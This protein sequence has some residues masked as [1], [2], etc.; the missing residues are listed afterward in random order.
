MIDYKEIIDNLQT[1]KVIQLMEQLGATSYIQKENYVIFPTICHNENPE[2]ASM[3]LYYYENT[4]AFVCYTKDGGMSIFKFL[5]HY[6]ETR[7]IEYDWKKDIYDVIVNCSTSKDFSA[8]NR[9]R[10]KSKRSIYNRAPVKEL[11]VYP[12]GILNCFTKLY[13]Q[14]WLDEGITKETMDKYNI[15]FS[16]TQNKIII[17]HYN[18]NGELVG[19]RGRALDQWEIENIGKY[20]PVKLENKWYSHPLSLN[21]YGLNFNKEAIKQNGYCIIFEAEKSVML[22]ENFKRP[23]CS[24]AVCGSQLN[25]FALRILLKECQPKQIVLAF[26]NEELEGQDIYFDK[27]YSLCEKY[28]KYCNFSFIYDRK[29]LTQLKDAPVDRG[30]EIFEELMQKRIQVK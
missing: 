3:K 25:K 11:P 18:V 6:Y 28:S 5:K 24:V 21:L 19:I 1:D 7:N 12:E 20:M 27:L 9:I 29:G 17:P 26:D 14:E 15:L 23:N 30:E 2:E 8:F 16:T 22:A 10:Y 4:H 13:P